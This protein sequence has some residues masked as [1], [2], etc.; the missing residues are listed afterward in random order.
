[1]FRKNSRRCW[2]HRAQQAGRLFALSPFLSEV[3]AW[4]LKDYALAA[5]LF[6][7]CFIILVHSLHNMTTE[8]MYS[9][10]RKFRKCSETQRKEEKLLAI[11]PPREI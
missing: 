10:C 2:F 7:Q 8:V 1:M 4:L 5:H 6:S 11:L 3:S 9:Y